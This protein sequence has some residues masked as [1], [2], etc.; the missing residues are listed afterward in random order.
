MLRVWLCLYLGVPAVAAAVAGKMLQSA[1]SDPGNAAPSRLSGL[2]NA[3]TPSRSSS[4]GQLTTDLTCGESWGDAAAACAAAC[5]G[6]TDEE[7]P[8]GQGCFADVPCEHAYTP[9]SGS[10]SGSGSADGEASVDEPPPRSPSTDASGSGSADATTAAD[11]A[12]LAGNFC[13]AS[14][15]EAAAL[16]VPCGVVDGARVECGPGQGCFS[17]VTACGAA[18]DGDGAP[19]PAAAADAMESPTPAPSPGTPAPTLPPWTNAPFRPS[20]T[21][22]SPKTVIGYYASWQWY[23]RDKLADPANVDFSKYD[24]INFAFFQ[25][26]PRG[27]LYGT[28]EWADPQL[29]WGPYVWDAA[30]QVDDG[31]D[32]NYFCSWDGPVG[33]MEGGRGERNCMYHDLDRGLLR[34]ARDAGTQVMPSIGGWT[35]SDNFPAIARTREGRENFARQ[36]AALVEAYGFDGVDLDWEYPGEQAA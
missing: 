3:A 12:T 29:L 8:A 18:A 34:R 35:L 2:G 21:R 6:G 15:A 4:G 10:G 32:Q 5:P 9:S 22:G 19:A 28:D 16:C 13:G 24:R 25:P 23:D 14:F 11:D 33:E 17:D 27:N 26:S 30:R 7:C 1:L 36:C 31:P 20:P